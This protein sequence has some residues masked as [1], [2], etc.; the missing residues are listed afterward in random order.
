[1]TGRNQQLQKASC[2]R[3]SF[4]Q[5]QEETGMY[6]FGIT[7]GVGSGKS[8][9]MEYLEQ[10]YGARVLLMDLLGHELMQQ[11]APCYEP[12]LKLFGPEVLNEDGSFNRSLIGKLVF[13]DRSLLE[14][15]NAIVHPAVRIR[16][17]ELIEEARQ[18]GVKFFFMESALIIEEKYDEMCDELWYVYAEESVR[19][20]RLKESRGYSDEKID[21]MLKN[22][23]SEEVF[24][25]R[26]SF[27]IDNSSS[28]DHSKE[29]ID[30]RM[31]QY[32]IM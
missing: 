7:G 12:I 6:L 20:E 32:E 8:R 10:T 29:Q 14:Q 22:Q 5:S 26:S 24:R 25:S 19:R 4:R 18:Q 16:V 15:L 27:V 30:A 13:A 17:T 23:L 28:F 3:L 31:R 2:R 9:V 21:L 1:M 11:G